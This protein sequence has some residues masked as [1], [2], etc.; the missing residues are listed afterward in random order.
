VLQ[1]RRRQTNLL[2][3]LTG[4]AAKLDQYA[5]GERFIAA[6]EAAAGPRAVDRCWAGSD[7]L[8]TMEEIRHPQRW[9]DRS[10]AMTPTG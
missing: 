8:P 10:V 7:A 4:I 3:R 5:A 2:Q 9:I 1:A 6:I